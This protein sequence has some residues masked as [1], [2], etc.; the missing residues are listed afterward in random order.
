MIVLIVLIIVMPKN[1]KSYSSQKSKKI[2]VQTTTKIRPPALFY[3][4]EGE[5]SDSTTRKP[6]PLPRFTGK[7][8][9]RYETRQ[10]SE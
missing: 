1:K 3:F 10:P 5:F 4:L 8:L 7:L 9:L 6:K 2:I